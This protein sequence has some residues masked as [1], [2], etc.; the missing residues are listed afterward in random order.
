MGSPR[1]HKDA[2]GKQKWS[3][4]SRVF[5]FSQ[6]DYHNNNPQKYI[7]GYKTRYKLWY[8]CLYTFR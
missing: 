3:N 6:K 4:L 1:R 7:Y 8:F 5:G 2:L